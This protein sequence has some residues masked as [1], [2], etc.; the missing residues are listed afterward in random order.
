[1]TAQRELD[2]GLWTQ[3]LLCVAPL[4]LR[5]D[6]AKQTRIDGA[7]TVVMEAR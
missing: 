2:S 4:N 3:S 5:K 1:M 6:W 7:D